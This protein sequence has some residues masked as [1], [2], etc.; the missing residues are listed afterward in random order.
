MVAEFEEVVFALE[1]GE[2]SGIFQTPYGLHIAKLCDRAPA[3]TR[4]LEDVIDDVR[5]T[6]MTQRENAAIDAYT[7]RLRE[8]AT[9]EEA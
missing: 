1:V 2:I 9:I 4:P 5:D 6:L 7:D 8:Q 3:E